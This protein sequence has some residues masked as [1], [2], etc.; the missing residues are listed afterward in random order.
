MCAKRNRTGNEVM[1]GSDGTNVVKNCING[2]LQVLKAAKISLMGEDG[3][4]GMDAPKTMMRLGGLAVVLELSTMQVL[5]A[6][7]SINREP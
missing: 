4:L 1:A 3:C 5:R 6:W 7:V 2:V